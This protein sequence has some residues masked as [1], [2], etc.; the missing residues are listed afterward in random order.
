MVVSIKD[1]LKELGFTKITDDLFETDYE[2]GKLRITLGLST[3]DWDYITKDTEAF[4]KLPLG[5]LAGADSVKDI[6]D[7][8]IGIVTPSEL[9][10]ALIG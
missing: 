6:A 1:H 2:G 5:K 10:E 8:C 4:G 3:V 7:K 9:R